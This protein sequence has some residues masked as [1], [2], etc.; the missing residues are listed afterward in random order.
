MLDNRLSQLEARVLS[1][2]MAPVAKIHM[3]LKL[4]RE[5]TRSIFDFLVWT[6]LFAFSFTFPPSFSSSFLFYCV[7][8]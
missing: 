7:H 8:P 6:N 1:D 3:T 5:L 2:E 4:N